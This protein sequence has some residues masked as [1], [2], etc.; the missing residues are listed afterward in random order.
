MLAVAIASFYL[1]GAAGWWL[2]ATFSRNPAAGVVW[3]VVERGDPVATT[4]DSDLHVKPDP[5]RAAPSDTPPK[6]NEAGAADA[7]KSDA[8]SMRSDPIAELRRHNLRLPIEG[9]DV[10]SMKKGFAERR[11]GGARAHEAV[12]ILSPRNTPVHAVE[13]GTIAKLF[14]SKAGGIT[15]YQFDP[16]EHFCYYYAHLQSYAGGLHEGQAVSGGDTIGYVGTSGNAPPNTP[17]LHFQIFELTPDR[18]WWDGRAIDPYAVFKREA[19]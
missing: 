12:D 11:A 13:R 18:R 16:T 14:L 3:G 7:G 1:G 10:E 8:T 2:H 19:Q 6:Q 15:V 9:A 17:H 5:T 4:G